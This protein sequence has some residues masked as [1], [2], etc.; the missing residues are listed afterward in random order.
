MPA[1]HPSPGVGRQREDGRGSFSPA[2]PRIS[3]HFADLPAT[4]AEQ[5]P[6]PRP[7]SAENSS[8]GGLR[9]NAANFAVLHLLVACVPRESRLPNDFGTGGE[10]DEFKRIG[11]CPRLG[12][13]AGLG[14]R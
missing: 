4:S 9:T 13:G 11:M 12:Y 3:S 6:A 2:N 10:A 14:K 7:K 1:D 5:H 8:C